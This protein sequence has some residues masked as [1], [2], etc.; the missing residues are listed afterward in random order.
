MKALILCLLLSQTSEP[1][2]VEIADESPC[3]FP[4]QKWDQHQLVELK[5]DP[6]SL[7]AAGIYIRSIDNETATGFIATRE[8]CEAGWKKGKV[9]NLKKRVKCVPSEKSKCL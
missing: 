6:E 8:G 4:L 9:F 1:K 2:V 3:N 7:Q 5:I